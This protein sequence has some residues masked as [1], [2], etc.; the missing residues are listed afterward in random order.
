[1][2]GEKGGA[3]PARIES[4]M[5]AVKAAGG[6]G[7]AP[8]HLWNPPDCGDIDLRIKA[9]GSWH[10]MGSPIGR[11][12]LVR[13]FASVLTREGARFVLKT[14]AE[15]IGITVDDA[16]F[17]AVE[18]AVDEEAGHPVLVFRTSLDELVRCGAEHP[19]RFAAGALPGAFTPYVEVRP[20]LEAR[21]NRATYMDLVAVAEVRADVGEP[22]FGVS[23]GGVF[24]PI[25]PAAELDRLVEHPVDVQDIP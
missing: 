4:L 10:Y 20:G 5:A 25:M 18:M 14:P 11:P 9:D 17:L 6:R 2:T 8:V 13:L 21:L 1:M 12:A 3:P 15:K 22:M 23:S 24:F 7:P 16:P 19:L